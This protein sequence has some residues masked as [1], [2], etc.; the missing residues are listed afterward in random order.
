M[1]IT[2]GSIE[3]ACADVLKFITGGASTVTKATPTAL[4]AF[5]TLA[6]GVE[7]AIADVAEGAAAPASLIVTIPGDVEAFVAAWADVKAFLATLGIKA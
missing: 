7:A 2:L 4:A 5:G 1:K 3:V 6:T